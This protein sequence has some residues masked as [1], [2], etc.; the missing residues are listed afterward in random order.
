MIFL[1]VVGKLRSEV[2]DINIRKE[3]SPH[4]FNPVEG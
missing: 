2:C 1:E 3:T 4:P